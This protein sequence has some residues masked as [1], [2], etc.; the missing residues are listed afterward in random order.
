MVRKKWLQKILNVADIFFQSKRFLEEALKFMTV[1]VIEELL[2]N[3]Q[4][5]QRANELSEDSDPTEC[6]SALDHIFEFVDSLDVANG[7]LDC[8]VLK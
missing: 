1:D 4:I 7:K 6:E 3:I 8:I 5:V 2:K